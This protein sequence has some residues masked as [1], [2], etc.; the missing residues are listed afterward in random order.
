MMSSP[1]IDRPISHSEIAT[2]LDCQWKHDFKYVQRVPGKAE[3]SGKMLFGLAVHHGLEQHLRLGLPNAD[4]LAVD[5]AQ[6]R[7]ILT[8]VEAESIASA[9]RAG[10]DFVEAI[11][12]VQVI[13]VEQKFTRTV[14]GWTVTG[15]K[16]FV[17]QDAYQAVHVLDWK[18]T[19]QLP[20]DTT[21]QIDP[22]TA[23]YALDTMLSRGLTEIYAGRCYLRM[24]PKNIKLTQ[25][26]LVNLTST[27]SI[28]DYWAFVK[29]NPFAAV[30][31][32][33]AEQKWGKWWAHHED[34][35]TLHVCE[36]IVAQHA[37]TAQRIRER[38]R[39]LPNFRPKMCAH[40]EFNAQCQD[41]LMHGD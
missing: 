3:L 17:Y 13:G 18:T 23:I 8:P 12:P 7:T 34:L 38:L 35:L 37:A 9:V 19:D 29:N 4:Q 28:D 22:Q 15:S 5:Y 21:G 31:R 32:E 36:R 33:K 11:S 39:P 16:D 25:A 40:C 20:S 30:P 41:R 6:A 14:M 26:G 1:T 24:S 27:C 2:Y 10:L